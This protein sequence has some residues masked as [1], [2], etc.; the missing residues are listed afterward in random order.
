MTEPKKSNDM[1]TP[2]YTLQVIDKG[3][4]CH[5]CVWAYYA[6][7]C[8]YSVATIGTGV[9]TAE[10]AMAILKTDAAKAILKVVKQNPTI[11]K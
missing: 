7:D 8:Q 10:Q 9:P 3:V 4:S 5:A 6:E 2:T 1:N 11:F